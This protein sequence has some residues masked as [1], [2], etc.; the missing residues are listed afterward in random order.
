V[1]PFNIVN[2]GPLLLSTDY[3]FTE[4]ASRGLMLLCGNAGA[5]RLLVPAAAEHN[6]AEMRTGTSV[7]IERSMTPDR[8]V[9][10]VFEDGTKSPF[11]VALHQRQLINT[12]STDPTKKML[13]F[14]VYTQHGQAMK[15]VAKDAR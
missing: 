14:Y 1:Q 5:L 11:Y 7:T 2:E 9:D 12:T 6:L 8:A 13:P 15:F 3:W 10:V 4:P